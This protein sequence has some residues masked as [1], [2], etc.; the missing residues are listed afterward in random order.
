MCHSQ[1]Q[2]H[3]REYRVGKRTLGF[4]LEALPRIESS[5]SHRVS[6]SSVL[7]CAVDH[8]RALRPVRGNM[9]LERHIAAKKM[10][11]KADCRL[12]YSVMDSGVSLSPWNGASRSD[13]LG[14]PR[15]ITLVQAGEVIETTAP[16]YTLFISATI[17][18]ASQD[19]K[20]SPTNCR[21]IATPV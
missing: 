2:T 8:V 1:R 5:Y 13:F 7:G 16:T 14:F 4:T 10:G 15:R 19:N 18:Q 17:L 21:Y 3:N 9:D 6:S 12:A 11:R 20:D